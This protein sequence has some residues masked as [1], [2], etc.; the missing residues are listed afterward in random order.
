VEQDSKQKK[1]VS[2][3]VRNSLESG[4]RSQ[5]QKAPEIQAETLEVST[6]K[7]NSNFSAK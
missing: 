5:R 6:K 4:E 7:G 1:T 3:W 2:D